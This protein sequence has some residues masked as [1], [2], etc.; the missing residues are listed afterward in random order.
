MKI[1]N[2]IIIVV[3]VL[4]IFLCSLITFYFKDEIY[5]YLRDNFL[6]ARKNITIEK[7][8]YFKDKNYG[9]VKNT[10]DFIAKDK[11][12]IID[13]LYTILNSGT[14]SFT[15]YCSDNYEEC[16]LD[17]ETI[18]SD[19]V[20]LSD[21][22]NFVHPYNSFSNIHVSFNNYGK[23]TVNVIKNYSN[24]EIKE[25]DKEVDK[26]I[27]N[28]IKDN[29]TPR[30]KIRTIHNYIINNSNYPSDEMLEKNGIKAYNKA[31]N[32]LFDKYGVCSGYAD[33][34]ALFL[35]KFGYNNIKVSTKTHVWNLVY[36][37]NKW[38]HLDLTWIDPR[39]VGAPDSL[40]IIYFLVSSERLKEIDGEN[41]IY[42]Q[43]IYLETK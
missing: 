17:F 32:N 34:M 2:K 13:I 3:S 28:E 29:M 38:Q 4:F 36:V 12:H 43:D 8:E 33:S 6:E 1:I 26:I 35:E 39:I 23:L 15:F 27:K 24:E 18:T 41:R 42:N 7:N 22:S 14:S 5:I 30:D 37:E 20:L 31:N 10:N 25:I 16:L 9:F 40:E 19:K 11:E 21:I